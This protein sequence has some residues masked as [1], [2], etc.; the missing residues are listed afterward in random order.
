MLERPG[1]VIIILEVV[2]FS[3]KLVLPD[4]EETLAMLDKRDKISSHKVA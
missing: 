4:P 3:F 2:C 1:P